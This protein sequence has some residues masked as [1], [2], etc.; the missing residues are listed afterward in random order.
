MA[1]RSQDD[2]P[3]PLTVHRRADHRDDYL[4]QLRATLGLEHIVGESPPFV[5][6]IQQIP[7]I[8]NPDRSRSLVSDPH[9]V[10]HLRG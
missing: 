1:S 6:L 2:I 8:A 10:P 3:L 4:A 5:T 7:G 9:D